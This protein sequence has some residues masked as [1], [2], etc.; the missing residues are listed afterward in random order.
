MK[1]KKRAL[2]QL[3]TKN[4][5]IMEVIER[6]PEVA[7]ILMSYGLHCVGCYVS[8]IET[9]GQGAMNHGIDEETIDMM[10]KDANQIVLELFD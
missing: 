9:I 7:P 6:F 3:V 5:K 4:M 10:I 1:T 2:K 8:D